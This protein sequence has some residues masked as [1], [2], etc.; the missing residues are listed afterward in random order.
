L[1]A[2]LR[3]QGFAKWTDSQEGC[4]AIGLYLETNRKKG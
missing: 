4:D 3:D 1:I 2:G